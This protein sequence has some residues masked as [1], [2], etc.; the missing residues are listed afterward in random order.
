MKKNNSEIIKIITQKCGLV[1]VLF[2]L[3]VG[4]YSCKSERKTAQQVPP[5]L[6][7][8]NIDVEGMEVEIEFEKGPQH[9]HPLMVVWTES[10]EGQYIETLYVPESISKGVFQH[11]KKSKG[12]WEPGP[13]RRPAALPYWS[14]KRG[15]QEEDGYYIPTQETPM[16]D[17]ITGPTPQGNFILNSHLLNQYSEQFRILLE[18]NQSWDWNEFWTNDKYPDDIQYKTS[19]QPSVVY[20]VTVFRNSNNKSYQMLPLGHG[21][22]SGANGELY[23]DLSSLTTALEIAQKIT[24]KV[25]Q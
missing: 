19:S 22:Y 25:K 13:I 21:H 14:H 16:A 11:G 7:S 1:I 17:A 20:G 12:S 3:L 15:V 23:T 6:L 8:T 18:I 9:N 5:T 4:I 2:F 24:V 10:T